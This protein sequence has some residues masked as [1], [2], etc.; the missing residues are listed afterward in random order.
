MP[1]RGNST[2]ARDEFLRER[3]ARGQVRAALHDRVGVGQQ[4]VGMVDCAERE[5]VE[6]RLGEFIE[7]AKALRPRFEELLSTSVL[8]VASSLRARRPGLDRLLGGLGLGAF[9]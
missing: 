3:D 8:S 6:H 1:H 9:L 7:R 2:D 5:D 4:L